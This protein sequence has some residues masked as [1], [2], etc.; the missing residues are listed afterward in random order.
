MTSTLIH[1]RKIMKDN[2]TPYKLIL[3]CSG[4]EWN[5]IIDKIEL[6]T[7]QIQGRMNLDL[8][9]NK[10][11]IP[12]LS[13]TISFNCLKNDFLRLADY[14]DNHIEKIKSDF[15][16]DSDVFVTYGLDFQLQALCGEIDEDS[17][18]EFTLR[19]M[20]L[21]GNSPNNSRVY[22]GAEGIVDIKQC[23]KFT[24]QIRDCLHEIPR[25]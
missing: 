19:I 1:K 20:L 17:S 18:G 14:I 11:R 4:F 13:S 24:N 10:L 8:P 3:E 12:S 22:A 7:Q 25:T 23:Y 15:F 6:A 9:V 16:H 2:V 5:I 21:I